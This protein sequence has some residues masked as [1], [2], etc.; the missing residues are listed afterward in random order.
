MNHYQSKIAEIK[1]RI[2]ANQ[3]QL[4]TVIAL[5]KDIDAHF[6]LDLNLDRLAQHHFVSK[7]HL[8][9]LFKQ[10]YGQTPKQYLTDVRL[11]RSKE[12]LQQ[13]TSVTETCFAVGFESLGSFSSLFKTRNGIP[14]AK[15]QKEQLSRSKESKE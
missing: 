7:F 3:N 4:D 15:Y 2:Y 8:L 9:R 10:Y 12:L 13:G 6:D 1:A 5:R 14:P 11:K